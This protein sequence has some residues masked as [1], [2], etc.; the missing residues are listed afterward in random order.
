MAGCRYVN[1]DSRV[2]GAEPAS[3]RTVTMT[4]AGDLMQHMPQI[5]AA[6]TDSTYD[7]T[8]CFA[9]V[10]SLL[11]RVDI[12]VVN[13]ETTLN[14][15]GDYSG[16]P[17]FAAPSVLAQTL[18][19]TGVDV[20]ITANNHC[21]DRGSRGI[22]STLDALDACHV[23]HTGTFK[24]SADYALHNP[25]IV[26]TRGFRI[27][28]LNYT[29]STNGLPV[30]SDRIV[31]MIDTVQIARDL[32]KADSLKTD[33]K[34]VCLHWGEEY[35][36]QPLDSQKSLSAWLHAKGVIAVIGSHPH[37]IEPFVSILDDRGKVRG[38][39][40]YSLG[41][42]VS[43]Q[44]NRYTD[45]GAVVTLKFTERDGIIEIEPE[46]TLT[47]VYTS[48]IDGRKRYRILPVKRAESIVEDSS[49]GALDC[50]VRDSRSLL[51]GDKGFRE[52]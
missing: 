45:G 43:N 7:Y 31:N 41:N 37:V 19:D 27:A 49:R 3:P 13:L 24:D 4:F 39:T 28:I 47:W 8:E 42:F 6:R 14:D 10:K 25:L 48:Y 22:A 40:V 23:Y 16:Y 1:A 26:C 5:D 2:A 32:S 17:R 44:R 51:E 12:T 36:R 29:Y 21:A 34:V 46:Y 15:R 18:Y 33:F 50:F 11:S 30:P 52:M 9:D 20:A 35:R 38:V